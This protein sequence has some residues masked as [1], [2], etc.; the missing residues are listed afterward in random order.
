MCVMLVLLEEENDVEKDKNN[1]KDGDDAEED[2]E[3]VSEDDGVDKHCNNKTFLTELSQQAASAHWM[4]W[5][6]LLT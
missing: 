6:M 1:T 4:Q 3:E 5:L 2:E